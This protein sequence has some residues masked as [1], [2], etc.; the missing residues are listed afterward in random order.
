MPTYE[1]IKTFIEDELLADADIDIENDTSLFRDQLLDSLNL[2]SLISFLEKT[3]SIKISPSEV[4]ID[5]MDS[6]DHMAAFI[7]KKQSK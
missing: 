6:I 4:S 3:F 7:E 1:Q 2:L 5:N